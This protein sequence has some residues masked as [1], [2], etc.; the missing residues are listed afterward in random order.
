MGN[1][2]EREDDHEEI[3]TNYVESGE[4]YNK[5]T[6]IVDIYFAS[7]IVDS[8]DPDPE[9]K[10]LIECRKRLDWDKWKAAIEAELRSLCQREVFGLAVPTPPKVILVGCKWVF[11]WKRNEH[12]Q[13]VRYKTR[14]VAQGFTQRPGID[15][16]ETYSP[17]MSGILFRYLISM[18]ANMNLKIQLMD[19]VTAYLYGSLDSEI[20]MKVPEGLKI[21][22]PNQNRNMFSVRLQQSLYGLK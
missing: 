9:P 16:D 6:T 10:S 1:H 3:A 22:G 18:A 11:L 21:P 7:K 2:D 8:M 17:I 4:S 12:G 19:V 5:K 14:L 15:Y 20:Y 13:V